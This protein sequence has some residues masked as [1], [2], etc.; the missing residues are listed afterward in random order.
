MIPALITSVA[1]LLTSVAILVSV[2][3]IHGEVKTTNGLTMAA[4]ADRQEG[5]RIED[6]VAAGDRTSK[7][8][9]YVEKLHEGG[10]DQ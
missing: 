6:D 2:L 9:K 1:S 4:L 8:Q 3:R 7:E 5:R 10:R